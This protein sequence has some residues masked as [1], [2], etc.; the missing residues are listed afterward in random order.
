MQKH[1]YSFNYG[2]FYNSLIMDSTHI[3]AWQIA[4]NIISFFFDV[5]LVRSVIEEG[6]TTS[7]K[8]FLDELFYLSFLFRDVEGMRQGCRRSFG[9]MV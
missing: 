6:E 7:E 3:R 4:I 5:F 8:L 9:G 1:I 2:H